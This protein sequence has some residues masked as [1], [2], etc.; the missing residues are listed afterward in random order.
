MTNCYFEYHH[1]VGHRI[2]E[3][4]S[5]QRMQTTI[6]VLNESL[7]KVTAP[8]PPCGIGLELANM[9]PPN[10]FDGIVFAY[11]PFRHHKRRVSHRKIACFIARNGIF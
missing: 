2:M 9:Q 6:P 7:S 4:T 8:K 5:S 11:V 1:A 3:P 10:A